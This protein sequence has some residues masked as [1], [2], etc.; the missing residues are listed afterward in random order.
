LP[1]CVK[2]SYLKKIKSK[3][4]WLQFVYHNIQKSNMV[5][6]VL[7]LHLLIDMLH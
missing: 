2:V 4:I 1:L 5:T 3:I 7:Y 6:M